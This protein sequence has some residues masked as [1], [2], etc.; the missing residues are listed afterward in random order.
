MHR[1]TR[2]QQN[3]IDNLHPSLQSEAI[4][5]LNAIADKE[6]RL[7]QDG[8]RLRRDAE[9]ARQKREHDCLKATVHWLSSM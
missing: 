8:E 7:S 1:F 6:R 2:A 4:A 9:L 3:H 5:Y